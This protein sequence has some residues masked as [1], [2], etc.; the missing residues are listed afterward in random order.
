ML[1]LK[2]GEWALSPL[3]VKY[4]Q[5]GEV[6]E[7][8]TNDKQWWLDFAEKWDHTEI[9]EFKEATYSDEQRARLEEVKDVEEGFEYYAARYA[10]DGIY[11]NELEVEEERLKKHP[12]R[13]LQ[14][15]N[16]NVSQGQTITESELESMKQG[17]AQSDFEIRLMLMEAK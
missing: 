13:V 10:L 15:Q 4:K 12:L 5:H 7:Q 1:Y 17:Q 8:Y 3:K 11:P 6:L 2:H 16:E 9:I 14:L